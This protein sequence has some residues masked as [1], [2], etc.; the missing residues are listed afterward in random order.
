MHRAPSVNYSVKRSRWQLRFIVCVNLVALATLSVFAMGQDALDART[1]AVGFSLLIASVAALLDWKRAPCGTLRWDGRHWYWSGFADNPQCRLTL[2]MDCQSFVMVT[3][4][5]EAAASIF[6][7]LEKCPSGANW[8]SLRRAIV[9]SQIPP[10]SSDKQS[11]P[12][13]QGESA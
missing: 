2:M 4:K 9:S 10:D 7:W 11:E 6:L 8:K 1:G 13:P 3:I 5:S 12:N